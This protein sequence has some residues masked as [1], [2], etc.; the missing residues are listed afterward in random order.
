MEGSFR[1]QAILGEFFYS[2]LQRLGDSVLGRIRTRPATM[3]LASQRKGA[4]VKG[5]S[6]RP[7]PPQRS[8]FDRCY[9]LPPICWWS[10]C[11]WDGCFEPRSECGVATSD[12]DT[13]Y[14]IPLMCFEE[15]LASLAICNLTGPLW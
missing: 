8:A 4:H 12:C 7:W 5:R 3:Q 15:E 11:G 1:R 2:P 13:L 9:E 14:W 6:Q 10:W